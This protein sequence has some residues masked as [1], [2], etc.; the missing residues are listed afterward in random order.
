MLRKNLSRTLGLDILLLRL[1]RLKEV[2]DMQM[3]FL[4]KSYNII[5]VL[6]ADYIRFCLQRYLACLGLSQSYQY[7]S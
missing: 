4:L 6:I 5:E 1:S 2:N 7:I 3:I